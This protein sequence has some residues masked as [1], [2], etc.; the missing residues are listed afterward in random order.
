MP[1]ICSI[2]STVPASPGWRDADWDYFAR[3]TFDDEDGTPVGSYDPKLAETFDGLEL[4]QT[5]PTMW[6]EFR[7]LRTIPILVI[8]GEHSDLLSAATV[9]RMGEEHPRVETVTVAGEGHAP[10]L[11]YGQLLARVSAFVTAVEGS[12]P[13]VDAIIPRDEARFDLDAIAEPEASE[14]EKAG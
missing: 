10:L 12:G 6:D 11:R 1:P 13:P 14:A 2:A 4:D 8:R 5:L 7:A 9:T 3:L